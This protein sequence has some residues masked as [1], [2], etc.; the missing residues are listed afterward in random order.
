MGTY[1]I[2]NNGEDDTDEKTKESKT[3]LTRVPAS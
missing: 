3:S 1:E 2:D